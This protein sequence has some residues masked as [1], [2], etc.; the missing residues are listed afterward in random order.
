MSAIAFQWFI[1]GAA[2]GALV[3]AFAHLAVTWLQKRA[4]AQSLAELRAETP[5]PVSTQ[6]NVIPMRSHWDRP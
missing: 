6:E 5:E 2:G 3:V 1:A 4:V